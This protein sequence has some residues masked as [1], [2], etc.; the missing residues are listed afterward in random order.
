MT[1]EEMW[2]DLAPVGRSATSGGYFRQPWA[3]AETELRA[4]FTE[5]EDD[6]RI[7][8]IQRELFDERKSKMRRY[9]DLVVGQPGLWALIKF[10]LIVLL[11][12]NTPGALG[13]FLRS[14]LYP[15]LLG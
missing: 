8:V 10:E 4:W 15:L 2:H 5:G 7:T 12:G 9:A 13:L 6:P 14:K 11:C 1:F 3:A